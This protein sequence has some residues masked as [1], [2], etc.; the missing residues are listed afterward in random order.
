[1]ITDTRC[2][3]WRVVGYDEHGKK[4]S[5]RI[6]FPILVD[7]REALREA[8]E[9]GCIK[10]KSILPASYR[11]QPVKEKPAKRQVSLH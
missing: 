11:D 2:K 10:V 3:A 5:Y 7:F 4:L 9:A 1:M 6:T 8:E